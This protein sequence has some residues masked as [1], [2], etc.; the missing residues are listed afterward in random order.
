MAIDDDGNRGEPSNIV[1]SSAHDPSAAKI[2]VGLIIGLPVGT[3]LLIILIILAACVIRRKRRAGEK[4]AHNASFVNNNKNIEEGGRQMS[5]QMNQYANT[6]PNKLPSDLH[7]NLKSQQVNHDQHLYDQVISRRE[8]DPNWDP[9]L[10]NNSE[11]GGA[12][13]KAG[14]V[15]NAKA[16]F[17]NLGFR[18]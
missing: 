18:K 7:D 14:H 13:I 8:K 5:S 12:N 9:T 17:D 16:M 10:P 11:G 1:T 15:A 3:I 6:A 2:T 4:G